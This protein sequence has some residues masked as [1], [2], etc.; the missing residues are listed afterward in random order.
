MY[1]TL[2]KYYLN[3]KITIIL[4]TFYSKNEK[5]RIIAPI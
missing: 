5:E 3:F 2:K 4:L 1:L